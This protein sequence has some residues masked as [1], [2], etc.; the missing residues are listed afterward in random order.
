M[1]HIMIETA[2]DIFAVITVFLVIN[3][4]CFVYMW[5]D[6]NDRHK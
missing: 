2:M 1:A 4:L 3:I 6:D 5:Y